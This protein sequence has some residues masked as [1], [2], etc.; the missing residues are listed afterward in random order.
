MAGVIFTSGDTPSALTT[1]PLVNFNN[2]NVA[3]RPNAP[4]LGGCYRTWGSGE[5]R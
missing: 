2:S 1:H 4:V 5:V 3:K